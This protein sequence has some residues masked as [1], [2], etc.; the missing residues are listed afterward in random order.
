MDFTFFSNPFEQQND[1]STPHNKAN[2]P[3][4]KKTNKIKRNNQT[5]QEFSIFDFKLIFYTYVIKWS[6]INVLL[7]LSSSSIVVAAIIV[8]DDRSLYLIWK[9]W[10]WISNDQWLVNFDWKKGWIKGNNNAHAPFTCQNRNDKYL[11]GAKKIWPFPFIQ[12]NFVIQFFSSPVKRKWCWHQN[13]TIIAQFCG[14]YFQVIRKK[15]LLHN[16]W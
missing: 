6:F 4:K 2:V 9:K 5:S 16:K 14:K 10:I 7:L 1:N 3:K 15:C 13:G 8:D 11:N 12:I